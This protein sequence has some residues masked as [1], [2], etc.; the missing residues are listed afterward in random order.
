MA[1]QVYDLPC[2]GEGTCMACKNKPTAEE[3]LTCKTCATPWHVACLSVRPNSLADT[4]QWDCPDCSMLSANPVPVSGTGESSSSGGLITAICA[5]E[6]DSSL[7][8]REKAKRRQQLLCKD[9]G[10]SD[11]K[12]V[13]NGDNNLLS[14]LDGLNCSFCMQLLERPVSVSTYDTL[15][16]IY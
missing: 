7:T 10:P 15:L 3:S 16:I 12:E 9:A 8:E 5:I 1:Q 4:L 6:S 13:T 14:I 2:D 11:D